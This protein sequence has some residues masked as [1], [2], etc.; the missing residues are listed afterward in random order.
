MLSGEGNEN[1]EKTT[2][3]L[4]SKKA[5]L[6]VQHTFLVHFFSLVLRD[7]M[8]KIPETS[9]LHLLWRKCHVSSC[10][11][12]LPLFFTILGASISHFLTAAL[13][14][15]RFSSNETGHLPFLSLSLALSLLLNVD[16]KI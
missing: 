11:P 14:F 13:K 6:H 2:I 9:W 10:Y 5:T 16:I 15:S 4:I 1:G 8:V 3:G 7:Y 12:S